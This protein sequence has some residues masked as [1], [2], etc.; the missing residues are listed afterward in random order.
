[1]A[2]HHYLENPSYKEETET[3]SRLFS[4]GTHISFT[5]IGNEL[6]SA[7]SIPVIAL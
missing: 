4:I 2:I 3:A 6:R 7:I 1:M 5:K